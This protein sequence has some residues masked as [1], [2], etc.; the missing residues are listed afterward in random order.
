MTSS[1]FAPTVRLSSTIETKLARHDDFGVEVESMKGDLSETARTLAAD[2]ALAAK[3]AES[4]GSQSME[5]DER[6]KTRVEELL[7]IHGTINLLSD[8]DALEL[9]MA[10]LPNPPLAQTHH[11]TTA[12]A[13]RV[14]DEP[15]RSPKTTRN[16]ASNLKSISLALSGK[17]V[18]FSKVIATTDEMVTLLKEEQCEDDSK[19]TYCI[20]SFDE[21]E[22][23]AKV[24]ARQIDGHKDAMEDYKDQLANT[25]E[26]IEAVHKSTDELD[27]RVSKSRRTRE[28][29]TRTSGCYLPSRPT[30][31]RNG[32]V[33]GGRLEI[34]HNCLHTSVTHDLTTTTTL[35][36]TARHS[37]D[38]TSWRSNVSSPWVRRHTGG[39]R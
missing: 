38:C 20:K 23:E 32:S 2:E 34:M 37:T 12:V 9:F 6:K 22:D 26:R 17:S 7:A 35:D 30:T 18:D 31:Q 36:Y 14:M 29:A 27:S 25:D 19:K 3:L 13:R 10:T 8:D 39:S 4:C 5:W 28:V 11:G 24:S 33:E 15:R 16:P 1:G 21:T